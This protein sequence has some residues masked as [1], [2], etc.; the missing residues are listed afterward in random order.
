MDEDRTVLV[1]GLEGTLEEIL[2][3]DYDTLFDKSAHI[4]DITTALLSIKFS[5][6][7]NVEDIDRIISKYISL[8]SQNCA[9]LWGASLDNEDNNQVKVSMIGVY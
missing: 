9:V 2:S 7:F 4:S 6:E 8:F 3:H 1:H 5:C